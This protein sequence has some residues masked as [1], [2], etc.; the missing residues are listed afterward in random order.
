M[1]KVSNPDYEKAMR[2]MN[3]KMSMKKL[4]HYMYVN[5]NEP[6]HK[7]TAKEKFKGVMRKVL[8]KNK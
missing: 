8:N 5:D 7:I 1:I 4:S 6:A 2:S 3:P